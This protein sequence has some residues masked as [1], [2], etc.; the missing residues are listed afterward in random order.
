MKTLFHSLFVSIYTL[1]I[2]TAAYANGNGNEH[3]EGFEFDDVIVT[4]GVLTLIS[5]IS[6]F[7]MGY[8]MPKNRKLL[9]TWHKRAG[10]MT[11]I[12][13]ISHALMVLFFD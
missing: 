11:L 8:C 10:I 12:L 5:M 13:G 9:F 1:V 7:L 4:L 6:T 3:H 2:S